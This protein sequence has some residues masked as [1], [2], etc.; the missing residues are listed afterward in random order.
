[1]TPH[2]DNTN[3]RPT[4]RDQ[5]TDTVG[6]PVNQL[7][8]APVPEPG[9]IL[10]AV[11]AEWDLID[12]GHHPYNH[13]LPRPWDPA[14]CTAPPL[15]QELWQWLDQYVQWINHQCLWDPAD[16]IPP[17]W[18]NHPHLVHEIAVLAEQRRQASR[19]T[20]SEALDQWQTHTLPNFVIRSHTRLRRHCATNH[21]PTPAAPAHTRHQA[22]PEQSARRTSFEEDVAATAET[23]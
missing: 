2:P 14:T 17:C 5:G 6:S 21:Q 1:M 3:A 10:G 15:R 7:L 9:E 19:T 18:P 23:A 4:H 22:H 20:T 8:V 13:D 16:L 12:E 11:L